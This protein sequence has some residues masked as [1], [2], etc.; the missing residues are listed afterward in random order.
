M[1]NHKLQI[2]I[3]R[4]RPTK[5]REERLCTCGEV[6]DENHFLKHCHQ[7]NHV[8]EKYKETL[9]GDT[10]SRILDGTYSADYIHHLNETKKLYL[11]RYGN[12]KNVMDSSYVNH[13]V[14]FYLFIY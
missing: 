2:E 12:N 10:I 5:P 9:D 1:G 13:F 6:E 8:R 7:Y 11:E 14:L 3:G 4:Q